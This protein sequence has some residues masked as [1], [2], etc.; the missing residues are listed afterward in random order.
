[1]C[2]T[3]VNIML[4]FYSEEKILFCK[5]MVTKFLVGPFHQL[6]EHS[7]QHQSLIPFTAFFDE[8]N[9]SKTVP[10]FSK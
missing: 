8:N 9:M 5:V 4:V 2:D 6:E 1:M 3:K 7:K 10:I